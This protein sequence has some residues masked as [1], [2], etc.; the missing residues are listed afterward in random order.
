[1]GDLDVRMELVT[2]GGPDFSKGH[3]SPAQVRL[4]VGDEQVGFGELPHTVPNLFG[5]VGLSCGYAA[6]DSVDPS[7]YLAPFTFTGTIHG[8]TLD[9]TGE[10][11]VHPQAEMTRIMTEQ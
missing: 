8:V 6:Y 2:T 4:L 9:V 7:A 1:M 10:S 3:G 11:L 5:I